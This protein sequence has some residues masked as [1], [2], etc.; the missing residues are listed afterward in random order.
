M[1]KRKQLT[2]GELLGPSQRFA[3]IRDMPSRKTKDG[4]KRIVEVQDVYTQEIF[5]AY[6]SDIIK[7][8]T[9]YPPSLRDKMTREHRR[10]WHK[11]EVKTIEGNT[12]IL[13]DDNIN[14]PRAGDGSRQYYF[15]N[16]D[17]GIEFLD[18]VSH[19]K[20][21]YNLGV[22]RSKGE[23]ILR[24]LLAKMSIDYIAEYSFPDCINPNTNAKLKFDFY[25]PDYNCCIEYDGEQHYKGWRKGHDPKT[26]LEQ[27]Q[28]RDEIKN[29]YCKD[30]HIRLI[31]IP[32]TQLNK[33]NED[34]IINLLNLK[35]DIKESI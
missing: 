8:H 20:G 25:L 26:S 19:V 33:I 18:T 30:N 34:Y 5:T 27:V 15:K 35:Q 16:I 28:F 6:L 24:R 23:F 2:E 3:Y 22:K 21:G 7:G 11:G 10:V 29:K 4:T 17:T 32:Y 31:R 14:I 12:I 13:V 9:R 1:P